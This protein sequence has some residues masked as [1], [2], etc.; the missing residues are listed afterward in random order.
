MGKKWG[1]KEEAPKDETPAPANAPPVQ[2]AA[3]EPA[4]AAEEAPAVREELNPKTMEPETRAWETKVTVNGEVAN[5]PPKPGPKAP[6]KQPGQDQKL[7][8]DM[9]CSVR[10]IPVMN[11]PGMKAFTKTTTATLQEWDRTFKAY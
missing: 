4:L 7:T 2:E 10:K 11:R 3:P 9:Y 5:P 6:K 8:F 1:S